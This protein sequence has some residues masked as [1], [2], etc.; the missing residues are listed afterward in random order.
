[1]NT[2]SQK[3]EGIELIEKLALTVIGTVK[4]VKTDLEDKKLNYAEVFGLID[5]VISLVK[6]GLNW[7]ALLAQVVDFDT[8]EG[9]QFAAFLVANGIE[10]EKAP[11][12]IIHVAALA[13]KL[14]YAYEVDVRPIIEAIK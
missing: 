6:Q 4:E 10:G 2:E 1:M 3:K 12:I 7:K 8:D 11:V 14:Y 13:E 5:N 9:K